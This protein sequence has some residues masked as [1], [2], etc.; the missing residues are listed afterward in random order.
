MAILAF[1]SIFFAVSAQA[2]LKLPATVK[3]DPAA[4]EFEP[5]C[6]P[7]ISPSW[8]KAQVIEGVK[9]EASEQCSPDNPI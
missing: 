4:L 8:R 9:I 5:M 7:K 1:S 2:S 3:V 6:D